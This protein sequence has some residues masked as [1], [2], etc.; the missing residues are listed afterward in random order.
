MGSS[1]ELPP[2]ILA[3]DCLD[4][5]SEPSK[6]APFTPASKASIAI[7]GVTVTRNFARRLQQAASGPALQKRIME[8]SGWDEQ[9]IFHSVDWDA[10]AKALSA[11][12]HAQE[13]FVTKW[14]HNLPPTRRHTQRI[15]RAESDLCQ[16]SKSKAKLRPAVVALCA[17]AAKL[18]CLD[19]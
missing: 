10:Q 2:D 8:R 17:A 12:E 15:G 1:N 19:R 4:N 11:L 18:D 3:T 6:L 9:R 13:L 16:E 5:W 14:A 7:D